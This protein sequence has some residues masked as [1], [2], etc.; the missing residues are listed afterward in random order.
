MFFFLLALFFIVI[1]SLKRRQFETRASRFLSNERNTLNKEEK[2]HLSLYLFSLLTNNIKGTR[3]MIYYCDL[4]KFLAFPVPPSLPPNQIV[5]Y[6]FWYLVNK[7]L[8]FMLFLSHSSTF[9]R[10]LN[11]NS[12]EEIGDGTFRDLEN[13]QYM[14]VT[15]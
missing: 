12:I 14:Y 10:F 8:H 11:N 3:N 6:D 4:S 5:R 13:L 15:H 1:F 7:W 2:R 9:S